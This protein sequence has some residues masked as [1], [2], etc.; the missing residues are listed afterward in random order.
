MSYHSE[1]G[2]RKMRKL[3]SLEVFSIIMVLTL[4]PTLAQA[5]NSAAHIYIA[6]GMFPD[7]NRKT[8][9]YYGSIAPDFALFLS[10]EEAKDFIHRGDI[11]LRRYARTSTR[12]AFA[13]GWMTHRGADDQADL[14]IDS[15]TPALVDY[16]LTDE[17]FAYYGWGDD[18]AEKLAHHAIEK[19]IDL[20]LKYHIDPKLPK[21]L[22]KA[23]LF[24]SWE[25]RFLLAKVYVWRTNTID[26]LTLARTE[27]SFRTL[28][29][30][31]ATVLALPNPIDKAALAELGAQLIW[32]MF[33]I[34]VSP[35]HLQY[36]LEETIRLC[37][38]DYMDAFS[39]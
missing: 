31:Y 39:P 10:D 12:R 26:W 14:Y 3:L 24:R 36:I 2:G 33:G 22:M 38:G 35:V 28:E 4:G 15:K 13:E 8:D 27:L 19:A 21:K 32:R 30:Q 20:L 29:S 34:E 17:S 6:E 5:F 11:D 1:K 23:A 18:E 37:E 7:C 16:L 9:L 25:D